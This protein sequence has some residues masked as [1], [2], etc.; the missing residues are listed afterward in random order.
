M[1]AYYDTAHTMLIDE[2]HRTILEKIYLQTTA[3]CV[4]VKPDF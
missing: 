2:K 3:L 1:N 4:K